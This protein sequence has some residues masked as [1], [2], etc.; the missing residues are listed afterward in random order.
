MALGMKLSVKMIYLYILKYRVWVGH[1]QGIIYR[2][3]K[4]KSNEIKGP[5]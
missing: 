3:I 5:K 2:L 1:S 4:D